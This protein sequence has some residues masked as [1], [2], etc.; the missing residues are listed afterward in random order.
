MSTAGAALTEIAPRRPL[1]ED[2]LFYHA[3]NLP[4]GEVGGT[5]D[6]RA[7]AHSY[8][9][10]VDFRNRSVLEVG[11]ASGFLSF[12]M[13]A[14]GARVT[15]LE[16]SLEH[17]WDVV[18]FEG[19]DTQAWRETFRVNIQR[20]RNS[21][22]YA[23]HALGSRV[24]MIETDPYRIPEAAGRF[25]IGVLTAVLLHC[26]NPF[27]ML[28]SVAARVD[29]AVVVT[30]EYNAALGPAAACMFQPHRG[31]QQV[32]TWW[33]FTPQFFVSALG[34]LGFTQ[35]RVLLHTQRQP[36]EQREVS[37]FTV[38]CEKPAAAPIG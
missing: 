11:P 9:G 19:F 3:L 25:D 35:A 26:R 6:L 38:V 29:T 1:R 22:W 16:P 30:E 4:E 17:L 34:L 2:C 12:W 27:D 14:S 37:M 32:D 31:V 20:V 8:L 36:A 28:Q 33:Q 23:H 18:P 5:W 21:F 10:E 13:E 15:C 24:R 7:N